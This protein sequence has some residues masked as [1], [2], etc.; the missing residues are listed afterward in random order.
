MSVF[1]KGHDWKELDTED[2]RK[3]HPT[4]KI[5][6]TPSVTLL[7][8]FYYYHCSLLD[9]PPVKSF[10]LTEEEIEAGGNCLFLSLESVEQ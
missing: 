1:Q 7:Y 9:P 3:F 6:P 5:H 4:F 10:G 2:N 8:L